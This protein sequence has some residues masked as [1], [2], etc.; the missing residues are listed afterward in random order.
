M[1]PNIALN[2]SALQQARAAGEP[3][4]PLPVIFEK[5]LSICAGRLNNITSAINFLADKF[6]GPTPPESTVAG[7]KVVMDT[8]ASRVGDIEDQITFLEAAI[9]RFE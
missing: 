4:E 7:S 3:R 6:V 9:Q 8:V 2:P 5:R 1:D